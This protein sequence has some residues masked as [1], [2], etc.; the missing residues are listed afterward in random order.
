MKDKSYIFLK[1]I[2]IIM[3]VLF[4]ILCILAADLDYLAIKE[5][6]KNILLSTPIIFSILYK[7]MVIILLIILIIVIAKKKKN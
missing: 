7:P 5:S 2:A 6:I 3:I 1:T 4:I